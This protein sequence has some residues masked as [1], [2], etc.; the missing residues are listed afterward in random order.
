MLANKSVHSLKESIPFRQADGI[1]RVPTVSASSD[2]SR[3]RYPSASS[4]PH[5]APY[6][7]DAAETLINGLNQVFPSL[8]CVC[9]RA[10]FSQQVAIK[11][12]GGKVL[13]LTPGTPPTV[14]TT[15]F[16]KHGS[17]KFCASGSSP[18]EKKE[19]SRGYT[20]GGKSKYLCAEYV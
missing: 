2:A 10:I 17:I 9:D 11:K 18:G 14:K 13:K 1:F 8:G 15:P 19:I 5:A 7:D 3:S 20:T 4:S 6:R 12:K 16:W